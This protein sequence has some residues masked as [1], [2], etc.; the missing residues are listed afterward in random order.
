M[1]EYRKTYFMNSLIPNLSNLVVK[2][3]LANQTFLKVIL[4]LILENLFIVPGL[5]HYKGPVD[6]RPYNDQL[7]HFVQKKEEEKKVTHDLG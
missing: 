6:N 2:R 7:H 4:W 5:Y 3:H 1:G